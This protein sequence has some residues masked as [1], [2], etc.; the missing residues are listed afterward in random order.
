MGNG[1]PTFREKAV[2]SS[3]MADSFNT[4]DTYGGMI[5]SQPTY[6]VSYSY[7]IIYIKMIEKNKEQ[8]QRCQNR[9]SYRRQCLFKP[10]YKHRY[11]PSVQWEPGLSR[12]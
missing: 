4:P 6:T 2:S 9:A 3:W 5:L 11:Q 8:R 10:F 7:M 12:G 1:I